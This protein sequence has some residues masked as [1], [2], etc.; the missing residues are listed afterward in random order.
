MQSYIVRS[1][2]A[3]AALRALSLI[4]LALAGA[5]L[6]AQAQG[7]S[8]SGDVFNDLNG[9]GNQNLSEPGLT[10]WTLDLFN[11]SNNIIATSQTGA[12]G[13]Y[14]FTGVGPGSYTLTETLQ[15]GWIETAPAGLGTF[16]V[17][18][19]SGNVSGL[20]F[21]NFEL[22]SVSGNIYND[23]NGNGSNDPGEPGL[24]GWT[25]DLEDSS[26]DL[27]ATTPTDSNGNYSFTNVGPGSFRLTE[28]VQSGWTETQP[29]SP[30]Y[31][32]FDGVSGVNITDGDF[33]NHLEPLG[34]PNVPE[35]GSVA[36]FASL[37][38]AG[39][40]FLRRRRSR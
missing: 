37:G 30:G 39:A 31:Y 38:L 13:D 35:P 20:D 28:T 9:D 11:S 22:Q 36:L 32:S 3:V 10:G 1:L 34:S 7:F 21:G 17:S 2:R 4:G 8:I 18:I 33:G 19:S 23:L 25:A 27:I 29:T 12:N 24:S 15:G 26:G 14:A 6:T 5:S 16:S 40:A